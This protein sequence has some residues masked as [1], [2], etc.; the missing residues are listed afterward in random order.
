MGLVNQA[1]YIHKEYKHLHRYT[2]CYRY[3]LA[4]GNRSEVVKRGLKNPST[5]FTI[6]LPVTVT[7][8]NI[9]AYVFLYTFNNISSWKQIGAISTL[10]SIYFSD[11]HIYKL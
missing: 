11:M 3:C 10:N 8:V 5:F 2:W 9:I 6:S 1:K 7:F 4:K